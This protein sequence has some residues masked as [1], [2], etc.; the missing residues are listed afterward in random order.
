MEFYN[1]F[2]PLIFTAAINI[3]AYAQEPGNSDTHSLPPTSTRTR[4]K[5]DPAYP[6]RIG[7]AYYPK[8]SKRRREEGVCIVN[9]TVDADGN[10]KNATLTS[11]SGH[12]SLDKACLRALNPGKMIPATENGK[13]IAVSQ[14]ITIHWLLD[15]PK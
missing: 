12:S 2:G 8:D 5:V 11:S 1:I 13:P 4:A 7:E 15:K 9:V 3:A 6:P 14:D 10:V